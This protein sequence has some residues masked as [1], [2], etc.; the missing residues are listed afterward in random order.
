MSKQIA[1]V[2]DDM[3]GCHILVAKRI[4]GGLKGYVSGTLISSINVPP[5]YGVSG[6]PTISPRNSVQFSL[7]NS[8]LMA[9]CAISSLRITS[10]NSRFM[11]DT[12]ILAMI[13]V[14]CGAF[15][16]SPVGVTTST[17]RRKY[18]IVP[19]M[20]SAVK[21]RAA[22]IASYVAYTQNMGKSN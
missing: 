21:K 12:A 14:I 4:F 13:T 18:Q 3:L 2:T 19:K 20:H 8:I 22:A 15:R 10:L 11:R 5:S 7:T 16:M 1:P 17:Q 9:H 6:G